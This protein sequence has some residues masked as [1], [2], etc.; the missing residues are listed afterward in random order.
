MDT[1]RGV[2]SNPRT[3]SAVDA[4]L[5]MARV[6]KAKE[7]GI[8]LPISDAAVDHIGRIAAGV[9]EG[10]GWVVGSRDGER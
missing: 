6:A 8:K 7:E 4:I 9:A 5:V 3:L 10:N 2:L 1:L